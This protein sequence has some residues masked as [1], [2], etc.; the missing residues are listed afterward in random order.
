MNECLACIVH[1]P[2]LK[3]LCLLRSEEAVRALGTGVTDPK[4]PC[5]NWDL[6]LGPLKERQ[7]L[8]TTESFSRLVE[9]CLNFLQPYILHM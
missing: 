3:A 6:N 2:G 8:L 9:K 4:L 1:V 7:M 5:G